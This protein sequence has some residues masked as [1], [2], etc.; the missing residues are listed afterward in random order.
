VRWPGVVAPNSKSTQ[1]VGQIDLFATVADILNEEPPAAAAVDSFS[2]LPILQGADRPV[3]NSAVQHS[4]DGYFAVREGQ[5][6]LEFCAGSGGWSQP[7]EP[8]AAKR[9]LPPCQLYDLANDLG[10]L[11]NIAADHPEIVER[12]T[13]L[14]EESIA[15]GRTTPGEPQSNDVAVQVFK[16]PKETR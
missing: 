3:R 13:H 15:N 6:K 11:R 10:E 8:R 5:W 12:L 7:R 1:L 4:A 9:Q 2:I 14:L 16:Q